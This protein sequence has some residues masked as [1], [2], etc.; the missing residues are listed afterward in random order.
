MLDIAP[1]STRERYQVPYSKSLDHKIEQISTDGLSY[2]Y[3]KFYHSLLMD[4]YWQLDRNELTYEEFLRQSP[5][6]S[7]GSQCLFLRLYYT[8]AEGA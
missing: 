3:V 5:V 7:S 8:L 4:Y 2:I 6:V 1:L